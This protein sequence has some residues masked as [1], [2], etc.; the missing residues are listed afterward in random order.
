MPDSL[1]T[2]NTAVWREW[3]PSE[4]RKYNA[5][6]T[7]TLEVYS[8]DGEALPREVNDMSLL[9]L[10]TCEGQRAL[11]T[12]DLSAEGEP[13]VIPDA[14]V[15][16]VAHHGSAKGTSQRF[17]NACTPEIAVVSVGENNYGHPAPETL[18]KLNASGAAVYET[19]RY[20]AIR[21]TWTG[22]AWR[23]ETYLEGTDE[24]E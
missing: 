11:F 17:L 4:G 6:G 3:F 9:T 10:V 15:L 7:A 14:D 24:V 2:L 21:L 8:P 5:N 23:T 13:E 20:G 22:G 1:Q 19:R 16:K 18:E 12:G